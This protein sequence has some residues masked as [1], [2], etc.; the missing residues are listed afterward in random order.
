MVVNRKDSLPEVS[1]IIEE[2]PI[3]QVN[4]M[5]FLS[6]LATEDEKCYANVKGESEMQDQL[7]KLYPH[8]NI[9]KH[10]RRFKKVHFKMLHLLII[11][12]WWRNMDI[13]KINN[14]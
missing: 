9:Q 2:N 8:F 7:L 5:I 11:T 6:F 3:K 12:L 4:S 1:I 13:Y 10:K 14:E